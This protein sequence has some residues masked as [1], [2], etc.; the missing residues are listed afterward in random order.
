MEAAALVPLVFF[1]VVFVVA[2]VAWLVS[3]RWTVFRMAQFGDAVGLKGGCVFVTFTTPALRRQMVAS[4]ASAN[5][6]L[7]WV[8]H[9]SR[10]LTPMEWWPSSGSAP[11]RGGFAAPLWPFIV[12]AVGG[13]G[14]VLYARGRTRLQ[15]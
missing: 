4:G 7:V 3:V 15:G 13:G 5:T 14:V 10:R 9:V 2:V 11:G 12:F 1:G 8:T 6:K